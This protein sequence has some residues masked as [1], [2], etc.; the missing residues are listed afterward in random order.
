MVSVR[1]LTK[2]WFHLDYVCIFK[3]PTVLPL[4]GVETGHTVGSQNRHGK[5]M[6]VKRKRSEGRRKKEMEGGDFLPY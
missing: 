4:K 2:C 5:G 6:G 1:R 3:P